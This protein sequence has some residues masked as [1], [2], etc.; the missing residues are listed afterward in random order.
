MPLNVV[1]PKRLKTGDTVGIIAPS[2]PMFEESRIEFVYHWLKKLGLKWKLGEH[3]F[4]HHGDLAGHDQ[5][6]LKDFHSAWI[7]DEVKAIIS[8]RGGTGAINLLPVIDFKL[9]KKNPKIFIGFS[10]ITGLLIPVHQKTGLVTFHGPNAG[11]FFESEYTFNNFKKALFDSDPI[12]EIEDP[13]SM[14]DFGPQGSPCRLPIR[15]GEATGQLTGGCLTLVKQLMG[16]EFEIDTKGKILFL[17]DVGEEPHSID[18]M[19][20]Q[21]KLAGKFEK[22]A[23]I[24][25]GECLDC[26]PGRSKRQRFE[27]NHSVTTML[28]ETL[29]DLKI[30]VAYGFRFGHSKYKFTLPLGVQAKLSVQDS[31][32]DFVIDEVCTSP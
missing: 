19:I 24:V 10:D 4:D 27:L 16:T 17:E 21:L 9:I 23:G 8:L 20:T 32:V 25:I 22:A 11:T 2:S 29:G 30:P 13:F 15:E 7:D 5:D 18:S 28:K 6:R 1:K 12:G 14:D 31:N 26:I 3:V